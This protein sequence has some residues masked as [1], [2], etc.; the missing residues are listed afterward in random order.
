MEAVNTDPAAGRL[1]PRRNREPIV[2][3]AALIHLEKAPAD[4]P[5]RFK[6]EHASDRVRTSG[7]MNIPRTPVWK[8]S[9]SSSRTRKSLN[10]KSICGR[11]MEMRNRSAAI[12][13][14]CL[15]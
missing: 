6:V 14:M 10:C 15:A 11:Q 8:R 12:S 2:E 3:G 7:N 9:G 13:S 5:D 1:R 4:P